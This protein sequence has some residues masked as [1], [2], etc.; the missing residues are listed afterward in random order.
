GMA[1]EYDALIIGTTTQD[2]IEASFLSPFRV[3]APAHPDLSG[4][5][6]TAGD[7]DTKQLSAAMQKGAMVADVVTTWLEKGQS[8]PTLCFA[9]DRAHAKH[10][11]A[12]FVTA[13]IG[14]AYIDAHTDVVER[15]LVKDRF[16]RGEIQVICNVGCLTTGVDWDVRCII[17]A[18]PT[19]SEMLYV[20]M[21]GRGLRTADGKDECLILDHSDNTLR[22][23]VVTEIHHATLLA[24]KSKQSRSTKRSERLP[25][26]CPACAFVKPAKI[27][28]CPACGFR[29]EARSTVKT[30][31]GDLYEVN[32]T[33]K[34]PSRA[35]R[36]SWYGQLLDLAAEFGRKDQ[37]VAHT[38][39]DKFGMWPTGLHRL[40]KS[41]SREVRNYVRAIDIRFAKGMK[42]VA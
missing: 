20:Q 3:F 2:L 8:R 9:V 29:P 15:Q 4:I 39:R 34:R 23:G 38:F 7:F 12:S 19:R 25:K 11:Q 1:S 10:L 16:H 17:L 14:C 22:M 41:A 35:D 13:G 26:P 37:W 5:K 32:G 6:M 30:V 33:D 27:H 36:Q 18:R 42:N 24:T 28:E 21:I 40:P 31:D